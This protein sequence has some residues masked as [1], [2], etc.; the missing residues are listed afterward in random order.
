MNVK[1][2]RTALAVLAVAG[3]IGGA[4]QLRADASSSESGPAPQAAGPG[5]PMRYQG[6]SDC[7]VFDRGSSLVV[8]YVASNAGTA[9]WEEVQTA[10][11]DG[12]YWSISDAPPT[13]VGSA[14]EPYCSL[15]Q[16]GAEAHV[17]DT[18]GAIN[19]QRACANLIAAG[20][21]ETS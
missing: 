12:A 17:Y 11:K 3:G 15:S 16:D 14:Q 9:C 19:G 10:A 2:L 4:L 6:M 8:E 20:W 5:V 1:P 13:S 18:G 21:T 7:F